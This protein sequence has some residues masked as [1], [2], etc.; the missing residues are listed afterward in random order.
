MLSRV[1][2]CCLFSFSLSLTACATVES[3]PSLDPGLRAGARPLVLPLDAYELSP[4]DQAVV[5]RARTEL[6]RRCM[7]RFG[8]TVPVRDA[9]PTIPL[10]HE[11]YLLEDER[12]AQ[13]RGYH[14]PPEPFGPP[15]TQS[16]AYT[17][18]ADGR[19][20]TAGDGVPPG[21]C[22]GE[23]LAGL[24]ASEEARTAMRQVTD[25]KG[26][27]WEQS[28]RD[29]RVAAAFAEWSS[30]MAALGHAYPN[31]RAA[32]NDAA[33]R[34]DA[35]T[36][37]EITVAVSDVR[38]KRQTDVVGVWATVE[39]AYQRRAISENRAELDEARN[40]IAALVSAARTVVPAN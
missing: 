13:T 26:W 29:S 21:G 27:S 30:C 31:P 6:F 35:P 5:A 14:P 10:N 22:E 37:H 36:P 33:F 18:A 32:N 1:I 28:V 17:A 39:A 3:E 7:A 38:C 23:A 16:S 24:A 15:I 20:R 12:A 19:G 25:L 2:Q 8:F 34:T 11:R 9:A 4:Q 40:T